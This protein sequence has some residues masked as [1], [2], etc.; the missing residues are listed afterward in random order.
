MSEMFEGIV[1]Q[2]TEQ[3]AKEAFASLPSTL[4][5]RLVPLGA[6]IHGI[7]RSASRHDVFQT[8]LLC[9]YARSLSEHTEAALAIFYDDRCALRTSVL[10]R[11]PAEHFQYGENDEWWVELDHEGNPELDG[12]KY[13]VSEFVPEAEYETVFTAIDAGIEAMGIKHAVSLDLLKNA[14]CYETIPA[15]MEK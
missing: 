8:E 11:P 3:T 7:Y 1:F 14:F 9:Q 13:R 5:L 12:K 6:N 15:L 2:S 10:F 4:A